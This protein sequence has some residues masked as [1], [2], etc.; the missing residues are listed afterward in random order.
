MLGAMIFVAVF[1]AVTGAAFFPPEARPYIRMLAGALVGSRMTKSDAKRMK[2]VI[3]PAFLLI[4]GMLILNLALGYSIHRLTG[5]KLTTALLGAAPG[6]VQDM[7]LIAEDMGA[8]A[9]QVAILQMV[10]VIAILSILPMLLRTVSRKYIRTHPNGKTVPEESPEAGRGTSPGV[11]PEA[12]L[13]TASDAASGVTPESGPPPEKSKKSGAAGDTLSFIRTLIFAGAGGCLL[14]MTA[15]P[16]GAMIGAMSGTFLA[17]LLIK[18]S[19][20]PAKARVIVQICAGALIGSGVGH[21]EIIGI[22]NIFVPAAILILVL[23]V[24]NLIFGLLIHKL[25]KLDFLTSLFASSAGGMADITLVADE[26]GADAPRV[27]II[28][29]MRSIS[30]IALFPLAIKFFTALA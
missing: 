10:R 8:D 27:A 19:F 16:A 18:P 2:D 15:L 24:A 23:L 14:N 9:A 13:P 11:Y 7:A 1:N 6:G 21:D 25:T 12:G 26:M 20:V 29:L 28:Q 30:V 22:G 17:T 4:F 3:Y 5:L